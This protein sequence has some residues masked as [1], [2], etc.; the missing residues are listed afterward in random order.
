MARINRK[1]SINKLLQAI[2]A[3]RGRTDAQ[4]AIIRALGDMKDNALETVPVLVRFLKSPSPF[5]REA[6]VEALWKIRPSDPRVVVVLNHLLATEAELPVKLTL[7]SVIADF[8]SQ[9]SIPILQKITKRA[10]ENVDVKNLAQDALDE[11]EAM[12]IETALQED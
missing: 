12:G 4:I 10:Q 2:P 5:V 8:R 6:T 9:D 1:S 3:N 7:T 11:L